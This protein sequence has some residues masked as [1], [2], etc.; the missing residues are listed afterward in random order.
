MHKALLLAALTSAA[1][2]LGGFLAVKIKDRTHIILGLAAGLMLGLVFFDLV[3][4][5]FN[6]NITKFGGVKSVGLAIVLGFLILHFSE[7]WFATHEPEDSHHDDHHH[8]HAGWLA[9]LAMVGH[10]FF[11]GLGVGAAFKIS[12]SLGIAVFAAIMVH[13]FSDGLN[14]VAFL[15][16]EEK[17]TKKARL[18]L[19]VDGI[20]RISGAAVGSYV[21]FGN[22]MIALYLAL[23]A[24]FVIYI[25]TSH[26]LPEAHSRHP[27]RWTLGATIVGVLIMWLVVASGA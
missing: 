14:T 19:A 8:H 6:Q 11:D 21:A 16:R 13:A 25:A 1:T 18:L 26:I 20:A 2:A 12:N 7:R 5:V 3:P 24:G 17:W 10:V 9:G 4:S 23:F 22:N 15:I 27:S